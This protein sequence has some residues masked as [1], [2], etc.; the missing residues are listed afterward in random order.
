MYE[1]RAESPDGLGELLW[2]VL[3]KEPSSGTLC[4]RHAPPPPAVPAISDGTTGERYC[5]PCM[6]AFRSAVQAHADNAL[7]PEAA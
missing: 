3:A 5:A 2:H 4:G 7:S 1:M 6:T